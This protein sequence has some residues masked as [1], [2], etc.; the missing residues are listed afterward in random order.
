MCL[1]RG[2]LIILVIH[3]THTNL[4]HE[5]EKGA[6]KENVKMLLPLKLAME[7]MIL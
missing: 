3:D 7:P 5:I 4:L 2:L 6:K 1:L